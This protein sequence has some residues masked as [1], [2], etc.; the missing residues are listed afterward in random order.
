MMKQAEK[1]DEQLISIHAPA[2]GATDDLE[3]KTC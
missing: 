2:G 3:K 1:I